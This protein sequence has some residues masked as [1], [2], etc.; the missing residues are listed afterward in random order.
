M[1]PHRLATNLGFKNLL[2]AY[3]NTHRHR[4]G[5]TPWDNSDLFK[6]AIEANPDMSPIALHWH[7]LAG[8]HAI[9]R[10]TF[11]KK[12]KPGA[13]CGV[14]VTDEVG[15]G[16]TFQAGAMIALLSDLVRRQ[17]QELELPPMIRK[18]A[19]H[20]YPTKSL[21]KSYHSGATPF[22]GDSEAIPN[23]PHLI[24]IPGGLVHQWEAELK[25]VFRKAFVDILIYDKTSPD[26]FW[27]EGGPFQSSN[28]QPSNII[29]IA[30]LSVSDRSTG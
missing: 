16:K 7:Q 5:I 4:G 26:N 8:V 13:T 22:F 14:L 29:I 2:P 18:I 10:K 9:I 12:A 30:S 6:G 15:L 3:F 24:I 23:L 20:H 25:I 19:H 27:M 11:S 17:E 21:T 1:S 28:Q